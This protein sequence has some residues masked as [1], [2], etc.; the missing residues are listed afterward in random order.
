MASF[1]TTFRNCTELLGV[2]AR[3]QPE[4][5]R[6]KQQSLGEIVTACIAAGLGAGA[7][8]TRRAAVPQLQQ[9]RNH[10]S[11]AVN[12]AGDPITS[13]PC[14]WALPPLLMLART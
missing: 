9:S 4:S 13:L 11:P 6:T 10:G 14:V 7:G 5:A 2:E 1:A 12:S 3:P 8:A